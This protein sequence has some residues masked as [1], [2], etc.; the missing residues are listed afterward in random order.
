MVNREPKE[1]LPTAIGQQ[2]WSDSRRQMGD[3]EW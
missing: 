2:K 3:E 1:I